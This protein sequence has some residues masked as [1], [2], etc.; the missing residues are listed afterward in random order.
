MSSSTAWVLGSQ[1]GHLRRVDE[2]DR[3][4]GWGGPREAEREGGSRPRRSPSSDAESMTEHAYQ[5]ELASRRGPASFARPRIAGKTADFDPPIVSS[6]TVGDAPAR[7]EEGPM[8]LSR[9]TFILKRFGGWPTN[10]PVRQTASLAHR[11]ARLPK[12][13]PNHGAVASS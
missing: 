10:G 7:T 9:T 13:P 3:G 5:P 6:H 12:P 4:D 1:V 11:A 8:T 2:M